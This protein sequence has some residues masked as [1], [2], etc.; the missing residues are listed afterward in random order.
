MSADTQS[1]DGTETERQTPAST[2]GIDTEVAL[3]SDYERRDHDDKLRV[4]LRNGAADIRAEIDKR[5]GVERTDYSGAQAHQFSK[6]DL[7]LV[8]LALG[9]PQR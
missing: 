1:G 5:L 9:G 3:P 7:A 4:L 8:L 6:D 2:N